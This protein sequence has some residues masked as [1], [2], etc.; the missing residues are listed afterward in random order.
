MTSVESCS[1][2][3]TA[4]HNT[5]SKIPTWRSMHFVTRV[6]TWPVAP[7]YSEIALSR[8]PFEIGHIY[9]YTFCLKWPIL[10]PPRILTFP[11]GTFCIWMNNIST[12][13]LQAYN[14]SLHVCKYLNYFPC[15]WDGCACTFEHR[16]SNLSSTPDD[17][18]LRRQWPDTSGSTYGNTGDAGSRWQEDTKLLPWTV[19]LSVRGCLVQFQ[20]AGKYFYRLRNQQNHASIKHHWL[21][22]QLSASKLNFSWVTHLFYQPPKYIC[23][24]IFYRYIFFYIPLYL[25]S[26]Q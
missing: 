5:F 13:I 23:I 22:F 14:W 24:S 10:W 3:A 11:P 17:A 26:V 8:K 7:L 1:C 16:G 9:T 25:Q 12:S 19:Q 15:Q 4:R 2:A 18:A 6:R 21:R 20:S